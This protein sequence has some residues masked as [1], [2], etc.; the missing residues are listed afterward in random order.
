MPEY[1]FKSKSEKKTHIPNK[2]QTKKIT[3]KFSNEEL[4]NLKQIYKSKI[5]KYKFYIFGYSIT[6]FI[7]I[8][9]VILFFFFDKKLFFLNNWVLV[10]MLFI[11]CFVMG[12]EAIN[13]IEK[14]KERLK[15][16]S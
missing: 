14:Y 3:V 8:T 12:S 13:K 2:K 4:E 15:N 16:V 5:T 6:F 11:G 10:G 1:A 9:G 7:L